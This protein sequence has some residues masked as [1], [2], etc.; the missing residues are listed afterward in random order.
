MARFSLVLIHNDVT[1]P[2]HLNLVEERGSDGIEHE[3]QSPFEPIAAQGDVVPDP[4]GR[5]CAIL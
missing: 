3:L 5:S 4:L 2:L 1:L